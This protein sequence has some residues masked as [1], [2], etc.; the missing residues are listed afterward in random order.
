[1]FGDHASPISDTTI[2]SSTGAGCPHLQHVATQLPYAGTVAVI[3]CISL[4]I[5]G[6]CSYSLIVGWVVAIILFVLSMIFL[7][8][9]WKD[10]KPLA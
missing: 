7:P 4:L 3:S 1:M 8:I 2:L 9:Y 5:S 6:L 10:K